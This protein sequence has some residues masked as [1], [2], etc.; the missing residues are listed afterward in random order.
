MGMKYRAPF[1]MRYDPTDSK[2]YDFSS[3]IW[4][5]HLQV[6]RLC[7]DVVSDR[8]VWPFERPSIAEQKTLAQRVEAFENRSHT[9]SLSS[10]VP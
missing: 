1:P 10:L 9:P 8:L 5:P 4:L 3:V 2:T 7:N 6:A